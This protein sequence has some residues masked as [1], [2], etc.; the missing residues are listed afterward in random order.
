[1]CQERKKSI[2]PSNTGQRQV[3]NQ[4]TNTLQKQAW[5]QVPRNHKEEKGPKSSGSPATQKQPKH[6]VNETE[7]TKNQQQS[8]MGYQ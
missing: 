4:V 1:M 5:N 2:I 6:R 7:R 8:L 3:Q